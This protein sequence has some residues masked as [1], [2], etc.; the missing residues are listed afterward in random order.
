MN[1]TI[2]AVVAIVVAA[3]GCSTGENGRAAAQWLGK[4]RTELAKTMGAPKQALPLPDTGGEL[5]F[6]S[7]QGHHYV[8]ETGANGKISSA[9][10]T[11]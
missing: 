8:F 7:Y 5:L 9:V 11:E 4:D 6:Y 3:T 10:Q 2:T 1:R